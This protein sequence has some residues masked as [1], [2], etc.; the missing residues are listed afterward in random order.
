MKKIWFVFFFAIFFL[1]PSISRSECTSISYF[2][3][4][5][6]V[7]LE[8]GAKAVILYFESKPVVQFELQTCKVTSSSRIA[9]LKSY[10]CDGD[11]ILIDDKRCVIL[12]IKP[13]GP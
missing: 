3:N 5:N 1:L 6:L 11:E 7:T 13:L 9:L 12:E 4:F 10:M 2:N 8:G